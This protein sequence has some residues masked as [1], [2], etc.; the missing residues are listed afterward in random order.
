M[1]IFCLHGG[2]SPTLDTLDHVR[3]LDRIQEVRLLRFSVLTLTYLLD[4][5]QSIHTSWCI[6]ESL[7][8]P[9]QAFVWH[10]SCSVV[11]EENGKRCQVAV[12]PCLLMKLTS[13]DM[14]IIR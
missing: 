4:H 9:A 5:A 8:T 10:E 3:A 13:A 12:I 7:M 2:L 6:L 14:F 1:Q 11:P